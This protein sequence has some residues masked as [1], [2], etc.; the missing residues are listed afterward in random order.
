MRLSRLHVTNFRN[1]A[2]VDI[3]LSGGAVI[4]GENRSGKSNLL[5]AIRLVLDPSLSSAQRKLTSDDFA[6]SLGSDPMGDG[7]AIEVSIEVEDFEDDEGLVATLASALI[8]GDPMRARLT[9]RYGPR[10]EQEADDDVVPA[11]DWTIYGGDDES[12]RIGGD[13]RMHLHHEHMHALRNAESDIA[14]WRRS[15]LRPLLEEVS[16]STTADELQ[17]V[18]EALEDATAVVRGLD[19]VKQAADRIERQTEALV[20]QLHRLEPTLALSPA[21]PERTL[22][23]LRLYLDG[24]AQRSLSSASLGTLNILYIALMQIELA[25]RLDEGDIEHALISIEEPEAH[26]HP[27]LQR[28]MFAGLL[29]GDGDKRSTVVSTHSPH[30]VSVTPPKQL[31]VMREVDGSTTA[32]AARVADLSERAWDDLARY[33]DATR[34]ELVFARRVLLVEGFA[35]Q[36]LLPLIAA[37][38][39]DFDEHGITVCPVHGT[40]FLSYVAFLRALGTPYA[41]ITDGDPNAGKGKTGADRV[42]ALLDGLGEKNAQPE[43]LGIFCGEETLEADLFDASIDNE[44]AMFDALETFGLSTAVATRVSAA[45]AARG[46]LGEEFLTFLVGARTKGRFAQRLASST[47]ALDPPG[48]VDRALEHLL[49]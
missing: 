42:T 37:P 39:L 18:A 29:A 14:A 47:E 19:S 40:H 36:V 41:V 1:L 35:E 22:R 8:S 24:E 28:R 13:L 32:F 34:S 45:R 5:H 12:R 16:R 7:C 26:L 38:D 33:L 4:V 6:E 20:G 27:H 49:S 43:D 17:T 2:D 48:Y 23:G 21:D 44:R 11:Y 3:P 15:P 30:I 9:Y 46:M 31:V 10:E 25:R